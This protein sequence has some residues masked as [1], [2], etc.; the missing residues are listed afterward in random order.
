M[1]IGSG[2]VDA[3]RPTTGPCYQYL[4]SSDVPLRTS[5]SAMLLPTV[6]WTRYAPV[7]RASWLPRR[8]VD[9][10]EERPRSGAASFQTRAESSSPGR[11]SLRPSIEWGRARRRMSDARGECGSLSGGGFFLASSLFLGGVSRSL[12]RRRLGFGSGDRGSRVC[13]RFG[14][15][16][17]LAICCLARFASSRA[18]AASTSFAARAASSSA[19]F[20]SAAFALS[21]PLLSP[22]GLD[23]SLRTERIRRLGAHLHLRLGRV[24]RGER[25]VRALQALD[26]GIRGCRLPGW[27]MVEEESR[28]Q[29]VVGK[30][31]A[32]EH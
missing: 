5:R 32:V 6:S 28:R 7:A 22:R 13:R 19:A 2:P 14:R 26:R 23:L 4:S 20:A 9:N 3:P 27:K 25:G 24:E 12:R 15:A 16:R 30:G 11:G 17:R 21:L 18:R 10:H 29:G 8:Q 1:E 31:A